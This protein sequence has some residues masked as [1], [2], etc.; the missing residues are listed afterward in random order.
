L[1]QD[2][3]SVTVELSQLFTAKLQSTTIDYLFYQY[4]VN[5]FN[6]KCYEEDDVSET[7]KPIEITI[8]CTRTSQVGFLELW[9]SDDE[10]KG[11]LKGNMN[12]VDGNGSAS[13]DNAII[14][15]C[16]YPENVPTDGT[17]PVV[18]YYVEIKCVSECAEE[19]LE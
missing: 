11:T 8:E 5:V 15:K 7:D 3:T 6:N 1:S 19:A 10:R 4:N 18:K 2:T 12:N 14:P 13:G 17:Y 16:C 9:V